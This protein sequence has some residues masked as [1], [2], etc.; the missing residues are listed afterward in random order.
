[1]QRVRIG[2]TGLGAV[3]LL[4]LFG[5]LFRSASD[6][7]PITPNGIEQ[8]DRQSGAETAKQAEPTE[9]LAELGV[10]PGSV[11]ANAAFESADE[12]AAAGPP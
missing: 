3:F 6:E 7:E 12:P 8:L 10:A 11:D 4:V 2:L 5:T 9:P 1:M